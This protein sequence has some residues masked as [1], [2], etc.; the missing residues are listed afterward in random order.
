M[1][2][3]SLNA[4]NR[5]KVA[6]ITEK[7]PMTDKLAVVYDDSKKE[8]KQKITQLPYFNDAKLFL[9]TIRKNT[10]SK[11]ANMLER[12][13]RF[14]ILD[15]GDLIQASNLYTRMVLFKQ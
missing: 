9:I 11:T 8:S 2:N 3:V 4:S 5:L 14:G 12:E 15:P 1:M 13:I 7:C 10:S 6:K